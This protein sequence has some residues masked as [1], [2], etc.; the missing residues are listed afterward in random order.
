MKKLGALTLSL[1]LIMGTAFADSPKDS[2]KEADAPP[3]KSKAAANAAPAKTNAEIAAEMEELRQA[4][5]SQQQELQLLKEELARRDRQIEEAR[6]AAVSANSK[7]A[8]ATV[9]ASEA[10]ATSAEVKTT[11]N[12]L[13][14][15]VANLEANSLMVAGGAGGSAPASSASGSAP[16]AN[17]VSTAAG[18]NDEGKGPLSIR[19]KGITLTPGGFVAAE[20]VNR[21]RALSDSINTQFNSIPYGGN[22]VGKLNELDMTAR[23]SRLSLLG[24]GKL[25]NTTITGY[26]EADW[27]G[28]G[29]TSN[30]RQSNSYVFR[31]RQIWGRVVWENGWSFTGG[32]TWSL[33]TE[34]RRGI[35]TLTEWIP[36]TVDPQYVVGFNWERQYGVRVAK[37]FSDKFA[38]AVSAEG[39]EQE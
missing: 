7:A 2:P 26:Y 1:F 27:L 39:P 16:A 32:Q 23:Q 5:Q 4:L 25:G 8:E 22:S 13:G 15:S 34:N 9:K 36:L 10:A 18:Q 17:P 14:S 12:A 28:T 21:Q 11:T 3:A 20:T 31:Q 30:N 37:N 35:S 6:E 24:E 19:F 38:L 33:V 29:V